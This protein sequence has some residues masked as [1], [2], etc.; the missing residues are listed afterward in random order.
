MLHPS[1]DLVQRLGCVAIPP[2]LRGFAT[3]SASASADQAFAVTL[4]GG[5]IAGIVPVAGRPN[6]TLLSGFV[7]L[8]VHLDKNYTVE[9][10]GAAQGDLFKAITRIVE[11]R[12]R[13]T[14][15]DLHERMLRALADAYACG[16]RALRTH[17]DWADASTV[18]PS[19]PVLQA[20]RASWADRLSLQW[21]SLTPLDLFA[22]ARAG[23]TI[24]AGVRAAD[25]ILG[26]FVYRNQDIDSKLQRVFELAVAQ[27]LRLDFHVDEGLHTDADGLGRVARL[28]LAHG[29][30]GR[31][32]C[33]HACSLS[34][35]D[36]VQ[37]QATLA[38]CAEAGIHLVSLPTTNL[39]LQGAWH[40]TPLQRGVTR[41][42]EAQSLGVSTSIATDNVADVFYPYGSYDLLDS[43]GL[44]VQAAHL[45]S[46][47]LWLD[48]ITIRPALAMGLAWDGRLQP[49]CPADLVLLAASNEHELLSPLGR[50]RIVLRAGRVLAS[51]SQP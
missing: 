27:G 13:W 5:R 50:Q 37:A 10:T 43:F 4:E 24:A 44:G 9:R 25:G 38:L 41:L 47:Q 6:G 19:I 22:D 17:L 45:T 51:P 21:V 20:L 26:A 23:A 40:E 48:S 12:S 30:Q 29:L 28:T 3:D 33:G 49:G 8:H 1:P 15:V 46:A 39:Y 16:T 2:G 18:P 36:A 11:E 7:D 34:V 14:S 31:V 32:T 35:Q 42:K